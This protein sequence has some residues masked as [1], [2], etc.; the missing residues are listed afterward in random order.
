MQCNGAGQCVSTGQPVLSPCSNLSSRILYS[1]ISNQAVAKTLHF[2]AAFLRA[3][4]IWRLL[5]AKIA[6]WVPVALVTLVG[7]AVRFIHLD[8]QSLWI[9]EYLWVLLGA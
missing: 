4:L 5:Q 3:S 2:P 9:D 1:M 6:W 8:T 7:A